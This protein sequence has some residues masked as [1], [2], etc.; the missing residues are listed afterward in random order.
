MMEDPR[1]IAACAHLMFIAKNLE[2]IGD[3]CTHIAQ[4]TY[5]L[6]TGVRLKGRPK[7]EDA[8]TVSVEESHPGLADVS[9]RD[10]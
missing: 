1:T 2:R 6:T 9:N 5:F 4:T 10:S 3:H 7:G 8:A